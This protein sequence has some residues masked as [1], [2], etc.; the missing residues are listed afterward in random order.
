MAEEPNRP[1]TNPDNHNR[2]AEDRPHFYKW[3]E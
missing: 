1:E 3:D 2:A